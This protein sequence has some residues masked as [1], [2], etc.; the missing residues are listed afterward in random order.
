ME[1]GTGRLEFLTA[2]G[3][4]FCF[5]ASWDSFLI[6]LFLCNSSS[7]TGA[8]RLRL[9]LGQAARPLA[10]LASSFSLA[11]LDCS[12][13]CWETAARW[14]AI[15]GTFL[16][17]GL[18]RVSSLF[19]LDSFQSEEP[20]MSVCP[21]GLIRRSCVHASTLSL[22]CLSIIDSSLSPRQ[23]SSFFP[24]RTVMYSIFHGQ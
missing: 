21:F 2:D 18:Q 13:S 20:E 5:V 9:M 23:F 7:E 1:P 8:G 3:E 12:C 15:G 14:L 4:S 22:H 11:A 17:H 19:G 10:F 24:L 16:P 6:L